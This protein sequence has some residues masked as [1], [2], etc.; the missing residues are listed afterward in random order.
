MVGLDVDDLER[1][2]A[3]RKAAIGLTVEASAPIDHLKKK[4]LRSR[5]LTS[6][7]LWAAA[8]LGVVVLLSGRMIT[9]SESP[10]DAAV[11]P[12]LD[13][14]ARPL[15]CQDRRLINSV[16][17][18]CAFQLS[19]SYLRAD[20]SIQVH[21]RN[22]R[23][24]APGQK[25]VLYSLWTGDMYHEELAATCDAAGYN[26]FVVGRDALFPPADGECKFPLRGIR[27]P[28]DDYGVEMTSR[29]NPKSKT[30]TSVLI[31]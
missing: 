1:K 11:L 31:R 15:I 5:I 19:A 24:P 14:S 30:I 12:L 4:S 20:N 2:R 29:D 9:E 27:L 16:Y 3:E 23:S 13:Q 28:I 22:M 6:P 26:R 18:D 8:C 21:W 10:Q 25:V 17:E 7:I